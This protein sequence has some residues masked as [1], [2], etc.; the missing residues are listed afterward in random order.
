MTILLLPFAALHQDEAT[1]KLCR[2]IPRLIGAELERA[3]SEHGVSVRFLSSRGTSEV[4]KAGLVASLEL[5]TPSDLETTARMYGADLIVT[6][7]FGLTE[8][9]LILEARIYDTAKRQEVYAKHFET[10]PAYYFD[11]VEELK[12]RIAQTLAIDLSEQERVALMSRATESWEALLYYLLAEDERYALSLGIPVLQPLTT[13]GLFRDALRIDPEFAIA[14]SAMEHYI[15]LII[16]SGI[17]LD[18]RAVLT[19]FEDALSTEFV[20]AMQEFV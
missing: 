5:P 19:S 8:R 15:V 18:L 9:N 7:R 16:E 3:L 17:P 2:Q 12:V 1:A 13:L 20:R 6:G 10:Y 11:S 4:G 14:R